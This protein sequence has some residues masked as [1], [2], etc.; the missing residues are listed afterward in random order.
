MLKRL[1]PFLLQPNLQSRLWGGQRLATHLGKALPTEQPYGE[2]WELHP[3]VQVA[4]GEYGG[5]TIGDLAA[6]YSGDL[7]G[8]QSADGLPLVVK[9]LDAAEWLSLQVHPND[10][11]ALQYEGK[12]RGQHESWYVVDAKPGAKLIGGVKS[13]TTRESLVQ[14]IGDNTLDDVL[15]YI[16]VAAGD[17]MDIA[18]GTIHA[19]GPDILV[20]EI[21]QAS[22]TTYRLS[23]W[24]R[25]GA[26]GQPRE[27]HLDKGLA[28]AKFDLRVHVT[29][30]IVG[31]HRAVEIVCS[32]F[33]TVMLH[34]LER[35]TGGLLSDTNGADF[36]VL[37]LLNG[38]AVVESV[39]SEIALRGGQTCLVPASTGTYHVTGS[40]DLLIA[41]QGSTPTISN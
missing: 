27:L 37:T 22:D 15:V 36:H 6:Q 41:S 4:E 30:P 10:T 38:E 12:R 34:R 9:F 32:P 20:Y 40:G 3:T 26:E 29:H 24:G 14:A 19:L 13:G 7:I 16:D 8:T 31:N 39:G 23:D 35:Y 18:A 5:R 21:Q 11:Q 28:V 25:V 2:S 1:S 17:L 33:Y